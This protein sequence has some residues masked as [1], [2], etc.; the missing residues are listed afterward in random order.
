[1]IDERTW[2][3]AQIIHEAKNKLCYVNGNPSYRN[4]WPLCK[5]ENYGHNPQPWVDVAIA[6]AK[7][8]IDHQNHGTSAQSLGAS[9]HCVT[10]QS[11]NPPSAHDT[12]EQLW[13]GDMRGEI[14]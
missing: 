9:D 2:K 11:S 5:R 3:L 13:R 10:V 6:Q 7:A 1:M 12:N 8:V 4:E 14:E